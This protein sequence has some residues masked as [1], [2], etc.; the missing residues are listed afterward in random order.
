MNTTRTPASW[1]RAWRARHASLF[2]PAQPGVVTAV[3]RSLMSTPRGFASTPNQASVVSLLT[4]R[5]CRRGSAPSRAG[6]RRPRS[7]RARARAAG[8]GSGAGAVGPGVRVGRGEVAA[9]SRLADAADGGATAAPL[10]RRMRQRV[11]CG[12]DGAG[13]GRAEWLRRWPARSVGG[14]GEAG[15]LRRGGRPGA[16]GDWCRVT[17]PSIAASASACPRGRADAAK[18]ATRLRRMSP[19]R[20]WRWRHREARGDGRSGD[21]QQQKAR[22]GHRAPRRARA[23]DSRI[24]SRGAPRSPYTG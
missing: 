21:D 5:W 12:G 11:R 10:R 1:A 9:R 2:Q 4:G 17:R 18:V 20:T 6:S 19:G 3:A 22:T 13:S 8:R 14:D 24:V 15:G 7:P 23:G 16:P